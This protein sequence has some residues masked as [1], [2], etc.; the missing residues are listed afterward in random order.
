VNILKG[1]NHPNIVKLLNVIRTPEHLYIIMELVAG[2]SL[3][4]AI[5]FRTDCT[6]DFVAEIAT[7]V[8]L[9]LPAISVFIPLCR[10]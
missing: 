10:Y 4:D 5:L 2:I 9:K 6:E 1:I 3:F 8:T 7:Q